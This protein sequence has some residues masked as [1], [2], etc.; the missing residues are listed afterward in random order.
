MAQKLVVRSGAW[1]RY[2]EVQLGQGREKTRAYLLE[3]PGP[4]RRA[5]GEDHGSVAEP[6]IDQLADGKRTRMRGTRENS[7][8]RSKPLATPEM[9]PASRSPPVR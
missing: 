7:S 9:A 8:T 3:N 4:G 1:F 2:G 5:A 6:V